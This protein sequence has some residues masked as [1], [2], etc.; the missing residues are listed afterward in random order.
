MEI[1]IFTFSP[2]Q[3]NTYVLYDETGEAIIIDAGCLFDAEKEEL[4]AFIENNNLTL[5]RVINTH[6]HLDH[7]FGNKFLYDTFGI[8]PEANQKDEF[9]VDMYPVQTQT[10]G[11]ENAGEAQP[12]K[13]YLEDDEK[14]VFGNTELRAIF[15]PGHSP[16]SLAY[17]S[18]KDNILFSGDVLF[19]ESIGRTDLVG[20]DY[21]TL[22]RS[23]TERLFTLPDTTVVYPGHGD[24]TT[25]GYEKMNNPYL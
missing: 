20:G 6:L 13:G 12:L 18:E 9:L 14:V 16:G 1:K 22:I 3:E 2:F 17:Y 21:A 25:I 8:A 10:F 5:K 4:K 11:F 23:I 15:V 19:L 24:N 7:Q